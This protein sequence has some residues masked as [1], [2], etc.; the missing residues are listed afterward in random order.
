MDVVVIVGA[1]AGLALLVGI[2]VGMRPVAAA[3]HAE[4]SRAEGADG[5]IT[6]PDGTCVFCRQPVWDAGKAVRLD[7]RTARGAAFGPGVRGNRGNRGK[8]PWLGHVPCARA[9]GVEVDP[10][11]E[12]AVAGPAREGELTCPSCGFRFRAPAREGAAADRPAAVVYVRCP[13]C[14]LFWDA[15][16]GEG[17]GEDAS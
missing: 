14:A 9:A 10:E 7:R 8:R 3:G 4:R 11:L 16:E 15:A 6:T 5:S 12:T 13:R 17:D 2:A 1:V